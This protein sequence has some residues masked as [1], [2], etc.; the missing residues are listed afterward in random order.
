MLINIEKVDGTG[1]YA[2]IMEKKVFCTGIPTLCNAIALWF[3]MHYIFN[4]EY[5]KSI[6]EVA[7]FLQEFIFGLPATRAKK[8]TTYLTVC[9]NIQGYT[10]M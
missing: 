10:E 2:L 7:I 8:S 5:S 1:T 4:L 9:S 6:S 3:A